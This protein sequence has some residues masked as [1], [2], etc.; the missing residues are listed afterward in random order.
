MFRGLCLTACFAVFFLPSSAQAQAAAT[1]AP[2]S[3]ITWMQG[4]WTATTTPPPGKPPI[5]IENQVSSVLGGQALSFTTSFNGV[6]QYQGLF[7]FDPASREIAFWYPSSA[8]ELTVGTITP[9]Q[10]YI[11]E[12]FQVT[13]PSGASTPFQV[14]I[15]RTGKDQYDWTLY[16]KSDTDWKALFTLHYH[17]KAS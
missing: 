16:T 10:N 8:G 9:A 4:T 13:S 2:L 6:Q 7:A 17:R 11:L 14:H 1:A 5:V 3:L 15:Q 12:D